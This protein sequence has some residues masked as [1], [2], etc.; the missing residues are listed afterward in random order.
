M[1]TLVEEK[2]AALN[3][4]IRAELLRSGVTHVTVPCQC[5]YRKKPIACP[6]CSGTGS[7]RYEVEDLEFR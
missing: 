7:I 1:P 3:K 5:V 6:Y 2:I 4:D